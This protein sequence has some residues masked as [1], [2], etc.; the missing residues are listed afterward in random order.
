MFLRLVPFRVGVGTVYWPFCYGVSLCLVHQVSDPRSNRF[1]QNLRTFAFQEIKH[2]E[3]S[4]AFGQLR[5][6]FTGNFD[7]WLYTRTIDFDGIQFVTGD[8]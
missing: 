3:V 7:H 6:K 1:H 2:V 4:V 5:P 8:L